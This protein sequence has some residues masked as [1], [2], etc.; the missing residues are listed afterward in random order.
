MNI[1][2]PN[3]PIEL[4][5]EMETMVRK[6][7]VYQLQVLLFFAVH[8]T[9]W[10][11]GEPGQHEVVLQIDTAEGPFADLEPPPTEGPKLFLAKS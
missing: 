6:L 8:A 9:C 10:K 2:N 4:C 7:S 11:K 5:E 3:C 1:P